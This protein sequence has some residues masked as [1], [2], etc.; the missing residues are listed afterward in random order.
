VIKGSTSSIKVKLCA[1]RATPEHF[2]PPQSKHCAKTAQPTGS[3][4]RAANHNVKNVLHL[5]KCLSR[6]KYFAANV[7]RGHF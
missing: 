1:C 4:T 2:K 6:D 3:Q 7:K 5:L